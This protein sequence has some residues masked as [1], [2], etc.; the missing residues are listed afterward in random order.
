M[1]KKLNSNL[2][3]FLIICDPLRRI[4]SHIHHIFRQ[5]KDFRRLSFDNFAS[6]I[7]EFTKNGSFTHLAH[8]PGKLRFS[9]E[10]LLQFSDYS[11][12]ISAYA[13]VFGKNFYIADGEGR[14]RI[15]VQR[16]E[17]R[18]QDYIY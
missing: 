11:T 1:M 6:R 14:G 4:R 7:L 18:S 13:E 10:K 9:I 16:V 8:D 2:K 15:I 17:A 3:V 12:I 5:H